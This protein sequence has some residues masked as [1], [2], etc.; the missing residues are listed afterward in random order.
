[1][2]DELPQLGFPNSY[3]PKY[4]IKKTPTIVYMAKNNKAVC[5]L[6]FYISL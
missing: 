6:I 3:I 4:T 5:L 2:R 1:M